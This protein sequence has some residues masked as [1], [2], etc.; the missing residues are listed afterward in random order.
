MRPATALTLRC[1]GLAAVGLAC[2]AATGCTRA[3]VRMWADSAL[4]GGRFS[5]QDRQPVWDGE[6]VTFELECDPGAAHFVVFG[7]DGDETV[8]SVPA[9]EGRY[10]WTR[11]FTCGPE[12]R[13]LEVYAIPFLVRGRCD[14]V[15]NKLRGTWEYYPGR[16]GKPDVQTASEQTI[17]VTVY[18][19]TL[20]FRFEGRG[21][22]PKALRLTLTRADGAETVVTGGVQPGPENPLDV[23]GPE[24]GVYTL[25]YTPT[26]EQVSRA[27]TTHAALRIVHADGSV[28]RLEQ[29]LDT[30]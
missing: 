2:A 25:A 30:P 8:V 12:P 24:G 13:R 28:Q 7:V 11:A 26:H 6:P 22:P 27:G 16:E 23:T 17:R 3:P 1:V 14:W 5:T 4:A 19:K 9:S 10:R 21:G 29:E 15:E 20:R 18:R